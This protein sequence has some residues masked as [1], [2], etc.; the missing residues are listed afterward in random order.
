MPSV[1]APLS[2]LT[3]R[4]TMVEPGSNGEAVLKA[5]VAVSG[6]GKED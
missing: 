6:V 1:L 5:G 2:C 4:T 3:D